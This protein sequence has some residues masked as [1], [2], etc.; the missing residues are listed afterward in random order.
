[1][2][3]REANWADHTIRRIERKAHWRRVRT[4]MGLLVVGATWWIALIWAA[5]VAWV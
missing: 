3:Q 1:M 4:V 5:R 2:T